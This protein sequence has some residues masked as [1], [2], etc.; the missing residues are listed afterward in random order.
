MQR[1]DGHQARCN[2]IMAVMGFCKENT[3]ESHAGGN[4]IQG[5]I[6]RKGLETIFP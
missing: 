1:A 6:S 3:L 2:W 5:V 4:I